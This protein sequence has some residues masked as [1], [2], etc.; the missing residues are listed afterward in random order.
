MF[1]STSL[2]FQASSISDVLSFPG[3]VWRCSLEQIEGYALEDLLTNW[4]E[5]FEFEFLAL[6]N[7]IN[8]VSKFTMK[9]KHCLQVRHQR[10]CCVIRKTRFR[11][12]KNTNKSLTK[13]EL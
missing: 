5:H 3:A 1:I 8:A 10:D 2:S 11:P 9:R 13:N 4:S 12:N 6:S 7:L